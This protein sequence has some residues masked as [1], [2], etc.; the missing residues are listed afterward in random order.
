MADTELTLIMQARNLASGAVNELSGSLDKAAGHGSRLSGIFGKLKGGVS[1]LG[2]AFEFA[3]GP[4]HLLIGALLKA[5]GA[6][7]VLAQAI[8]DVVTKLAVALAPTIAVVVAWLQRVIAK[9]QVG[10][11]HNQ[12]LINQIT[13]FVGGVLSTLITAL[14]RTV[15]FIGRVVGVITGSKPAMD[16]LRAVVGQIAIAFQTMTSAIQ[17]TINKVAQLISWVRDLIGFITK[18]IDWLKKLDIATK[19]QGQFGPRAPGQR[20]PGS[21]EGGWAGL[22]GP[23]LR[24]LGE[25][26]PEYVTPTHQLSGPSANSNYELVPVSKRDLARMVDEQLYFTLRRAAPTGGRI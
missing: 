26:G 2:S 12:P 24:M 4:A 9:V 21:A 10:V 3:M 25:R 15:D 19:S 17:G 20:V 23:E 1:L 5:T 8:Q 16:F 14:S 11:A 7:K 6:D 22:R 13:A 18:A